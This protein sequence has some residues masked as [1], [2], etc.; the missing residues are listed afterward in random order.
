MSEKNARA[1]NLK[2]SISDYEKQRETSIMNNQV[3]LELAGKC[4]KARVKSENDVYDSSWSRKFL[5]LI[6]VELGLI[7]ACLMSFK[8]RLKFQFFRTKHGFRC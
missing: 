4:E 2:C 6:L 7:Q 5:L 3:D 8:C 1:Q